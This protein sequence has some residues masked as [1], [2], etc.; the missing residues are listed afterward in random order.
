MEFYAVYFQKNLLL[1]MVLLLDKFVYFLFVFPL[2]VLCT[3]STLYHVDLKTKCM[4]M[5]LFYAFKNL[6]SH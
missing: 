4:K 6:S 2:G 3:F 1:I 5:D